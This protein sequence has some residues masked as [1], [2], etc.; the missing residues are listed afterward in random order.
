L[1]TT[2]RCVP[3]VSYNAEDYSIYCNGEWISVVGTSA[4]APQWAA[5]YA[6]GASATLSNL[7]DKA[8]TAYATYFRDITSGSTTSYSATKDY[9]YITGLGSPLTSNF[10]N[11]LTASPSSGGPSTNVTLTT[12]GLKGPTADIAY[13][14]PVSQKWVT[15]ASNTPVTQ[16]KA[17]VNVLAPDLKQCNP[18]GDSAQTGDNITFRVTDSGNGKSYNATTPFTL[19]RRGLTQVGTAAASGVFGAGTDLSGKVFARGGDALPVRGISFNPGNTTLFW[20]NTALGTISIDQT[21][22]FSAGI[23][24]PASTAGQHTLTVQNGATAFS[25]NVAYVPTL[26][27]D[28]TEAWH[29]SDFVINIASDAQVNETFYR[30]NGGN[31]QNVSAN[32]Q[33]FFNVEGANN[34]LEYWC[35][36]D[37]TPKVQPE[38]SY[39]SINGIKLDKTAPAGSISTNIAT[40]SRTVTLYLN[41]ADDVSGVASMR[42]SSDNSSWSN[43]ENYATAKTWNLEGAD[44]VKTV[45]AQFQNTAG[46][47][48]TCNC[49]V[50]LMTPTPTPQPTAQATPVPTASPA[51]TPTVNP[52]E[53]PLTVPTDNPSPTPI[54]ELSWQT[55]LLAFAAS[56]LLLLVIAKKRVKPQVSA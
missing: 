32:G 41:A 51:A 8:K 18:S 28:Y 44:G 6:L 37:L 36:W 55:A 43:W 30:I 2:N 52:T 42:F 15:V 48:S 16:G 10:L 54:P 17:T 49:T 24:V 25:V 19:Y 53:A 23:T 3:D 11:F 29:T 34:T 21:G 45:Y 27:T 9:D 13:L 39:A 33:P 14:D 46:L 4:G 40:E 56:S 7:Y 12:A 5:I 31:V 38:T 47:V 26:T 22:A 20:D 50:T 1:E 35:T